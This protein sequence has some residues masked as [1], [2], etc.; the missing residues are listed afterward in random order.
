MQGPI[1]LECSS[2]IGSWEWSCQSLCDT[3]CPTTATLVC[4]GP[5]KM[6]NQRNSGTR[7][8]FRKLRWM[9]GG[10]KNCHPLWL[11]QT[12]KSRKRRD[13]EALKG[14][15]CVFW[16]SN[17]LK[18]CFIFKDYNRITL[19]LPCSSSSQTFTYPSL[20]SFKFIVSL[21]INCCYMN[22]CMYTYMFLNT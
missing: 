3:W 20:C 12:W 2:E 7:S 18:L 13:R 22:V 16:I 4:S 6:G 15:L 10:S 9:W 1:P 21:F 5:W 8:H 17:L 14:T 11:L 19:L